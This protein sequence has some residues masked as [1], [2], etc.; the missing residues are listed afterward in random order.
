MSKTKL[1][2][3][4]DRGREEGRRKGWSEIPFL[5]SFRDN[6]EVTVKELDEIMSLVLEDK[7]QVYGC[8]LSGGGFGCSIVALL[9]KDAVED[10]KK[11][12]MVG[13][14]REVGREGERETGKERKR[15][16]EGRREEEMER[17]R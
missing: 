15:G 4:R 3:G 16:R 12:V 1:E 5:I 10:T 2:V 6:Y 14:R 8:R 9:H 13:D 11:R 7:Q 17:G